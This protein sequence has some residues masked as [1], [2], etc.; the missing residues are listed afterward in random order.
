M[1]QDNPTGHFK[2]FDDDVFEYEFY[3]LK[4]NDMY[5]ME[6]LELSVG[7][8]QHIDLRTDWNNEEF[9]TFIDNVKQDKV[10]SFTYKIWHTEVETWKFENKDT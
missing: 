3:P 1:P 8:G 7:L 10:C 4:N 5:N 2:S 6:E 9:R